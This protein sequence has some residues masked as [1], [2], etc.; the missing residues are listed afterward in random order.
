ML[1]TA[2]YSHASRNHF[3]AGCNCGLQSS[4]WRCCNLDTNLTHTDQLTEHMQQLSEYCSLSQALSWWSP[5]GS[6]SSLSHYVAYVEILWMWNLVSLVFW[7]KVGG[8]V[9]EAILCTTG[10]L[11]QAAWQYLRICLGSSGCKLAWICRWQYSALIFGEKSDCFFNR[12]GC[13]AIEN[14]EARLRRNSCTAQLGHIFNDWS[15]WCYWVHA[16]Q[17]KITCSTEPAD[18]RK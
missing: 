9:K 18:H 3:L 1:H 2:L 12:Q 15:L 5:K 4:L 10:D 11:S 14:A 13:K 17:V 6:S 16:S 7:S 8:I